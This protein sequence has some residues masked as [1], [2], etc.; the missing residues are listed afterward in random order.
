MNVALSRL[1]SSSPTWVNGWLDKLRITHSPPEKY[2]PQDGPATAA[3]IYNRML[4]I[5]QH[6]NKLNRTALHY[7][8]RACHQPSDI[9]V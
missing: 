2:M 3:S 8:L 1:L 7:L 5:G 4:D 9:E 6:K